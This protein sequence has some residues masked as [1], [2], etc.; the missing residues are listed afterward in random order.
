MSCS[1]VDLCIIQ[2]L[3]LHLQDA[4]GIDWGDSGATP[5]EIEVVDTGTDCNYLLTV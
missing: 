5:I 3:C 2:T 1:A 4:G